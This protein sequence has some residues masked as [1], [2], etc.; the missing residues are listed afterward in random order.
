MII[1]AS[2]STAERRRVPF[3]LVDGDGDPA[4][5]E[6]GGQPQI[7]KNWGSWA[8]TSNLLVGGTNGSYYLELTATEVNT[9]GVH[10]LRYSSANAAERQPII[11]VV[12]FDPYSA[13]DFGLSS[14]AVLLNSLSQ[15]SQ[16]APTATPTLA[17][18]IAYLFT[19]W[20]NKVIVTGTYASV[21]NDAGDTVLFK[22][23]LSADSEQT[24]FTKDEAVTGP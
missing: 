23:P 12:A 21:Y 3:F 15:P 18:A 1:K 22:L 16:G 4:T 13:T 17:Q 20:R 24:T 2:E 10:R 11:Q 5:G 19:Y 8:N 7:S 14:L 9:V 6:N